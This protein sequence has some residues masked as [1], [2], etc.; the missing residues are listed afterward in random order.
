MTDAARR[1]RRI[2]ELLGVDLPIVQAPM[3]GVQDQELAIAVALAGGLGSLPCAMLTAD[4]VRREVAI[5]RERTSKPVNLNF[6]CHASPAA[7]PERD[8]RW[9][10]ALE[11][12]YSELGVD[13]STAASG[14]ARS[15][16]DDGHCRIVEELKPEVVS[17]HFG[18]PPRALLD[19]VRSTG[20]RIL[21][22]AT[23]T[24]EARFLESEGCDAVIAQEPRR[25]VTA[26]CS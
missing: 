13:P 24:A 2:P 15:P 10:A 9:R 1:D 26:A 25:A 5:F 21:A 12:Y 8:A 22:S 16:F 19:R 11:R 17:F 14:P 7:D 20:A 6:F 4:G 23:T 3:A 18:L